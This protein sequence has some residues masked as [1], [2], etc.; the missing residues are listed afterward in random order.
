MKD[1]VKLVPILFLIF[2]AVWLRL[3]NLGYSDYQGDESR[4]LWRLKP[5]QTALAYLLSKTKGPLEFLITYLIRFIDPAFHNRFLVRLPFA[6]AGIMAVFFFYRLVQLHYDKK[7]ALY[8]TL[9]LS[10]NGLFVGLFRIVQY[11]PIIILFSILTL[12]CL[13]L[14]V[15]VERWRFSGIYLGVLFWVAALFSHYDAVF[16]APF[17]ILLF[18][19][20][21]TQNYNTLSPTRLKRLIIVFLASALVL[22]GYY[23]PLYILSHSAKG[24]LLS[25]VAGIGDTSLIPSSIRNFNLYNPILGI[26]VYT[27]LCALAMTRLKKALLPL[28]WFAFSWGILELIVYEP[29]THIYNYMIPATVLAALGLEAVE[30]MVKKGLGEN[31]GAV[32][33]AIWIA[34]MFM[35]LT[36][37]SH[38]IFVDHTPEYPFEKRR[39]LFWTIG[40]IEEGYRLRIYGFPYYRRWDEI[41]EYVTSKMRSGYY[42]T[43]EVEFLAG[44]YIPYKFDPIKAEYFIYIYN[45]QTI[46][47]RHL[48][49]KLLYWRKHYPPDKQ[50]ELDGKPVADVYKMPPGTLQKLREEGY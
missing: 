24:Y 30:L 31:W 35:S 42:V 46:F 25:R 28:A 3:A 44:Y 34:G 19:Q 47:E 2:T 10:T 50:F 45:P 1:R 12:Y 43:N 21:Y 41:G 29:G 48:S 15:K 36:A 33:N 49:R 32:F 5:G 9:F 37:I 40:G 23:I 18:A 27:A 11:Q 16:I 7:I 14:A 8:A 22:M 13:S 4:T 20:W 6:L 17:A 26:Y 38:L 39:I